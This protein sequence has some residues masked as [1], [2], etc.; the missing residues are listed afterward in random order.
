MYQDCFFHSTGDVRI[1]GL[2]YMVSI[3]CGHILLY[4]G[5]DIVHPQAIIYTN[6]QGKTSV[7]RN[8][9]Q[10]L[11]SFTRG[12]PQDAAEFI[13]STKLGYDWGHS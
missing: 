5:R 13:L 1:N 3:D 6:A 7:S 4:S 10:M 2:E 9:A 8:A 12:C 11:L